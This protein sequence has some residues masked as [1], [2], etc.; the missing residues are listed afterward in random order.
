MRKIKF[1]LLTVFV[2]IIFFSAESFCQTDK[3]LENTIFSILKA[4]SD[5]DTATL[6]SFI[7]EETGLYVL[8]RRGVFDEFEKTMQIDFNKPVPEYFPYFEFEMFGKIQYETLPQFDYDTESW[9]KFGLY[10]DTAFVDNLLSRTAKNLVEYR[11]DKIE[12]NLISQFEE[13]ESKSF[14]IILVDRNGGEFIFYLTK[15]NDNWFL[16]IIDRV[17]SDTSA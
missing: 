17:S 2:S 1:I 4:Y 16:T 10:V 9:D 14:R 3:E 7:N 15:L 12:S 11:E 6:N 8:F 13:I 5:K